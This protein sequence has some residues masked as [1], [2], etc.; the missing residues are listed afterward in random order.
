MA[1][2]TEEDALSLKLLI[3]AQALQAA[4]RAATSDH[5]KAA[6]EQAWRSFASLQSSKGAIHEQSASSLQDQQRNHMLHQLLQRASAAAGVLST[7]HH[8]LRAMELWLEDQL[9]AQ[10]THALLVKLE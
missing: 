8:S 6:S 9:P 3:Q 2:L 10:H 1:G 4:C 5:F 7:L